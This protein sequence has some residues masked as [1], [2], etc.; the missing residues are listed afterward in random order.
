MRKASTLDSN[1]LIIF[2]SPFSCPKSIATYQGIVTSDHTAVYNNFTNTQKC[3]AHLLRKAIKLTL[4][5]PKNKKYAEF[6][7]GLLQIF[8]D[9]RD[10]HR[11]L[12]LLR[13]LITLESSPSPRVFRPG[14]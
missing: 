5:A 14:T 6:A 4:L 10:V 2:L 8:Y 7:D 12:E 9:A 11:N 3:W 13:S 1:S